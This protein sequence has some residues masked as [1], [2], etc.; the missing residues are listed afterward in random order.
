MILWL[1]V[2]AT[3]GSGDFWLFECSYTSVGQSPRNNVNIPVELGIL[4]AKVGESRKW[5]RLEFPKD[6]NLAGF[7][8][9]YLISFE[10]IKNLNSLL[11]L[12]CICFSFLFFWFLPFVSFYISS[13]FLLVMKWNIS[14]GPWRQNLLLHWGRYQLTKKFSVHRCCSRF[15]KSITCNVNKQN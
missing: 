5:F 15:H 3:K 8:T 13:R 6:R 10:N 1:I 7:R 14:Q 2:N 12:W 9:G 11:G 4:P